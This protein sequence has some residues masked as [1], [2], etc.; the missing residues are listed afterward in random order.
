MEQLGD[1]VKHTNTELLNKFV[2]EVDAVKRSEDDGEERGGVMKKF[3]IR[4]EL[5][6]CS[7]FNSLKQLRSR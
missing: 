1:T 5:N 7:S 6:R 4:V 2:S 3:V